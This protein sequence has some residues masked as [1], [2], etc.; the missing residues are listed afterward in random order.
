MAFECIYSHVICT[1]SV[2]M[3]ACSIWEANRTRLFC[4]TCRCDP[5][6]SVTVEW[7]ESTGGVKILAERVSFVCV[8]IILT[9]ITSVS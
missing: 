7:M 6:L 5:I 3:S 9:T 8:C 4:F 2:I 1:A